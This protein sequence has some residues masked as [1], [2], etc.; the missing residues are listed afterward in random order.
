[1]IGIMT[2][3]RLVTFLAEP[4]RAA[5][6]TPKRFKPARS[7]PIGT[8]GDE[9]PLRQHSHAVER[10]NDQAPTSHEPNFSERY[11]A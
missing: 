10:E 9:Y 11:F 8:F 7:V 2:K 5:K 3:I 6:P 4:V 1:M